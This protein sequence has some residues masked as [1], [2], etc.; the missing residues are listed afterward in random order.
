MEEEN[1]IVT[2]AEKVFSDLASYCE[3]GDKVIVLSGVPDLGLNVPPH[4]LEQEVVLAFYHPV[5]GEIGKVEYKPAV[6]LPDGMFVNTREMEHNQDLFCEVRNFCVKFGSTTEKI[7]EFFGMHEQTI[8]EILQGQ[9]PVPPGFFRRLKEW[10]EQFAPQDEN[11]F[12]II[13]DANPYQ[14]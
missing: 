5:L 11:F 1:W 14:D 10:G 2:N 6:V 4:Y 8:E 13:E 3:S 9:Y 7:A 12:Q